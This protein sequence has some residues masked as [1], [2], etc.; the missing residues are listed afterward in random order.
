MGIA[1]RT[2]DL[3]CSVFYLAEAR[4]N[5]EHTEV[6]HFYHVKHA[7]NLRPALKKIDNDESY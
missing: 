1:S 6:Q 3:Q 4:T 2:R 7:P 5:Y